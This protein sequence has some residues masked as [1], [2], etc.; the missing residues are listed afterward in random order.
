V[1]SR[2]GASAPNSDFDSNSRYWYSAQ[3]LLREE[4]EIL[5]PDVRMV[6]VRGQ[7]RS[8]VA[9]VFRAIGLLST[10]FEKP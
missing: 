2:F 6:N 4:R 7:A 5:P 3:R 9:G 10:G 8:K 1:G